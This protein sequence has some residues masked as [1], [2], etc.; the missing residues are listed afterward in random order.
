M[1]PRENKTSLRKLLSAT[2]RER[3]STLE[4]YSRCCHL[5]APA[6]AEL[7][8]KWLA[9]GD[10]ACRELQDVTWYGRRPAAGI[11]LYSPFLTE[12][13]PLFWEDVY[14]RETV[15]TPFAVEFARSE[16]GLA[17]APVAPGQLAQFGSAAQ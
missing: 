11:L 13:E 14:D 6:M 16:P 9:A 10:F 5:P 17:G 4:E 15:A 1:A 8:H 12:P 7:L 2:G 3:W